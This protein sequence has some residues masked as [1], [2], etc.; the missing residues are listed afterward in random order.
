MRS[1]PFQNKAAIG[2][3]I[4]GHPVLIF[5]FHLFFISTV[6]QTLSVKNF[7][8]LWKCFLLI[9]KKKKGII[10]AREAIQDGSEHSESSATEV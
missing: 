7:K 10:S 4:P 1:F 3:Y 6:F 2:S 5:L 9:K 8:Q